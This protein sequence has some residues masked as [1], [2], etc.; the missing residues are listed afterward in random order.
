MKV[1]FFTLAPE[2]DWITKVCDSRLIS[3]VSF[4]YKVMAKVLSL[5]LGRFLEIPVM[6]MKFLS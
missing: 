6:R 2:K 5:S 1:T 4:A 3:F